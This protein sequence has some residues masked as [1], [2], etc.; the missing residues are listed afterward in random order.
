MQRS[1]VAK[2]Q[3]SNCRHIHQTHCHS[4]AVSHSWRITIFISADRP[5][6]LNYKL[7]ANKPEAVF[8]ILLTAYDIFLPKMFTI[9]YY[10]HD[11]SLAFSHIIT[12]SQLAAG[13][14]VNNTLI[15]NAF[16]VLHKNGFNFM[17]FNWISPFC[18]HFLTTLEKSR[19]T[20]MASIIFENGCRFFP[21]K[22]RHKSLHQNKI[23]IEQRARHSLWFGFRMTNINW[24]SLRRK[25]RTFLN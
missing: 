23:D 9:L 25:V 16:N 11:D 3:E 8:A 21:Y 7:W 12:L 17:N 1:F 19:A 15:I 18:S 24:G 2:V 14:V 4:T 22:K 10:K 5:N 13:K 20:T 6:E